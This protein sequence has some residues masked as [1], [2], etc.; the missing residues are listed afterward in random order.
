ML[1]YQ[2]QFFLNLDHLFTLPLRVASQDYF[3]HL[4]PVNCFK[5]AAIFVWL[6]KAASKVTLLL[7]ICLFTMMPEYCAQFSCISWESSK[8]KM[9][10]AY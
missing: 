8:A 10:T 3:Q 9:E 2:M 1:K 5:A 4:K 6:K 7:S